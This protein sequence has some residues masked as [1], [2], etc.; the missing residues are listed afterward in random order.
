MPKLS[1]SKLE[2]ILRSEL[3]LRAPEFRLES[4]GGRVSGSVISDSFKGKRDSDRQKLI[5]DA[6]DRALGLESVRSVGMLL[7]YTPQ[8]WDVDSIMAPVK[9]VRRRTA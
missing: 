5:W 6:L 7:A 3:S 8:E 9:R 4:A 2:R 1:K